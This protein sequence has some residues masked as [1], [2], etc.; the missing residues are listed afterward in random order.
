MEMLKHKQD[1]TSAMQYSF[2]VRN[3]QS[4]EEFAPDKQE[5]STKK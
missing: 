5:S 2:R 4:H 3:T 1:F